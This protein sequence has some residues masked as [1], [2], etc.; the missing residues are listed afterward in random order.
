MSAN[1]SKKKAANVIFCSRL[2]EQFSDLHQNPD[3][4]IATP[5]RFLHI[6]V[7][8][9]LSLSTV[10]YVVFDEADRF[11]ASFTRMPVYLRII[12]SLSIAVSFV[13]GRFL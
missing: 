3:I 13:D 12:F 2:D 1:D 9:G 8:M 5:G 4:V 11:G 7:E 6:L 10:E